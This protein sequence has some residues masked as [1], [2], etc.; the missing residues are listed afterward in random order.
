MSEEPASKK[1]SSSLVRLLI[2]IGS[3]GLAAA[4][5]AL[6]LY[7]MVLAPMLS[8]KPKEPDP[9]LSEFPPT[10]VWIDFDSASTTAVMPPGS[11]LPASLVMYAVSFYCSNQATADLIT[12]N[13]AWFVDELRELHSHHTREQL[14]DPMLLKNIQKQALLRCSE[15]LDQIQGG[16]NPE[17]RI[18]K[19][20]HKEFL[21]VDQ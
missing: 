5:V 13:K 18:L 12:N 10:A 9:A 21:A 15:I 16:K 20:T 8:D 11:N 17:N 19:V 6:L 1:K 14:D 3:A 4:I 2:M 7:K